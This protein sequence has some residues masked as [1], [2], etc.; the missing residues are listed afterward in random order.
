MHAFLEHSLLRAARHRLTLVAGVGVAL[1]LAGC[2][3]SSLHRSPAI[4]FR[5]DAA[6]PIGDTASIA[7]ARVA[8]PADLV[9]ARVEVT[10]AALRFAVRFAPRSLDSATT[11]VEF[12][13][14][15]DLDPSTGQRD[16]GLGVDYVVSLHAGP[17]RGATV[18]RAVI[19]ADCATPG[20]PCRFAPFD[21]ADVMLSN[22]EMEAVIPRSA[23]TKFDGRLNFRVIAYASLDRGRQTRTSD[24]IPNFPAQFVAVR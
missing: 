18:A 23:F 9:D 17:V 21:R 20:V 16:P 2:S 10:D 3:F 5:G 14:D 22:D 15:T 24:H 8:R 6:D 11:G 7:D 1:S 19:D 4:R 13:L 12:L